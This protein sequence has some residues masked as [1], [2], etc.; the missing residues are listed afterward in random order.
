MERQKADVESRIESVEV[1]KTPRPR[2]PKPVVSA[3][4]CTGCGICLDVCPV[5]AIVVVN[6]TATISD[7]CTGCGA[8]VAK[9][10]NGAL[11]LA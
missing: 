7:D 3:E 9:C 11:S 5:E 1:G 8:C 10:P 2:R 4:Q 6:G